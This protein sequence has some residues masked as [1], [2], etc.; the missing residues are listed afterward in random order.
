MGDAFYG[1]PGTV[2]EPIQNTYLQFN[3]GFFEHISDFESGYEFVN[4]FNPDFQ[5]YSPRTDPEHLSTSSTMD[6]SSIYPI[7]KVVMILSTNSTLI[8][9]GTVLEPIR[10]TY[11][12]VQPWIFRAYIRF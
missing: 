1:T 7:L 2:L 3:S 8:S 9:K 4:Q 11:L 12:P 10:N 6:F 5:R